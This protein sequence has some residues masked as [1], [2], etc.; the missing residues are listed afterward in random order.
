MQMS[1]QK[2]FKKIS[3]KEVYEALAAEMKKVIKVEPFL[4]RNAAC[5]ENKS[6]LVPLHIDQKLLQ[7]KYNNMKQKWRQISDDK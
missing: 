7:T 5:L 6:D 4:S 1:E 3:A 2:A